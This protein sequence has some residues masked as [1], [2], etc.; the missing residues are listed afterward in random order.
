MAL[1]VEARSRSL[2]SCEVSNAVMIGAAGHAFW[3]DIVAS[4]AR[5]VG[6]MV[7]SDIAITIRYLWMSNN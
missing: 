5:H 1:S 2:F 6:T 7:R 3:E 4:I